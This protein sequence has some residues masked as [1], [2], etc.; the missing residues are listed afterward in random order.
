M[1]RK[2]KSQLSPIALQT[3]SFNHGSADVTNS[4]LPLLDKDACWVPENFSYAAY[5]IKDA[6]E[7]AENGGLKVWVQFLKDTP[8]GSVQ[9]R[10]KNGQP[11]IPTKLAEKAFQRYD[12]K[13]ALGEVE[14]TRVFFG[15]TG[16]SVFRGKHSQVPMKITG[17]K[18]A[19]LGVGVYDIIWFWEYR[20]KSDNSTDEETIWEDRWIP[21]DMS[22]HRIYITVDTPKAPWTA[23]PS[24][25]MFG[26]EFQGFPI[27]TQALQ[28]ACIWAQGSKTIE[29]AGKKISDALYNSGKFYYQ[30]DSK[31]SKTTIT[32]KDTNG[33]PVPENQ[34]GMIY[35]FI[36][37][38]IERIT[39]GN[40]LGENVNCVDCSLI[41][42]SLTNILGGNLKVGKLQ[43]TE[44]TDYTDPDIVVNNRFEINEIRAIGHPDAETSMKGL[45]SE[46]KHYF[47]YHSIA[48]KP[49]S[50]EATF[51]NSNNLIFDACVSFID[52]DGNTNESAAN[53]PLDASYRTALAASTEEGTKRCNAQTATVR[54]IRL[55]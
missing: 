46:G 27:W 18:F 6:R 29:E 13:E 32:T 34:E 36:T 15:Q 40:G 31:Y 4:S 50:E 33:F 42:A 7:A 12:G 11:P 39:G 26:G 43:C 23:N 53:L 30:P 28:I 37:K 10:A 21:F 25:M 5:S 52:E 35:F 54:E 1:L 16:Q 20:E 45:E 17:S 48:W 2:I 47:S 51:D 3:I 44:S 9:I 19:E 41:V 24:T 8:K 55:I 49:E 38:A 22:W 14:P